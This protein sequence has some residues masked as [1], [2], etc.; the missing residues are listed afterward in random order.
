MLILSTIWNHP[1][2]LQDDAYETATQIG[3]FFVW[4][5]GGYDILKR[6]LRPENYTVAG[7][8]RNILNFWVITKW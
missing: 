2:H 3:S 4:E 7:S 8:L 5:G 6:P 1:S